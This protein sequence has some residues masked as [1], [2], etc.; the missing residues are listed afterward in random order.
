[1]REY[2]DT[3]YRTLRFFAMTCAMADVI[4]DIPL[5][6]FFRVAVALLIFGLWTDA[7]KVQAP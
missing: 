1:L 4:F 7:R 6:M 2:L 5:T 3:L